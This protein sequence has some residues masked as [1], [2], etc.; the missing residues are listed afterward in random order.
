MHFI[1][2]RQSLPCCCKVCGQPTATVSLWQPDQSA[3][4][5]YNQQLSKEHVRAAYNT[6]Q[7]KSAYSL[8]SNSRLGRL[9][10]NSVCS[11][12]TTS[13]SMGLQSNAQ[14]P[15]TTRRPQRRF[16]TDNDGQ[17]LHACACH[18]KPTLQSALMHVWYTQA[19]TVEQPTV[20]CSCSV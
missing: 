14:T 10:V 3:A 4:I 19:L 16:H 15:R 6:D 1:E 17:S 12:Q 9:A 11:I 5:T 7:A 20:S 13:C 2:A 8:N 18:S